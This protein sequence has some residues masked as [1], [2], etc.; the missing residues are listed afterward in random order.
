MV[1]AGYGGTILV[2]KALATVVI[3][4]LQRNTVAGRLGLFS[5]FD[6]GCKHRLL[7]IVTGRLNLFI[8]RLGAP[9]Y[10]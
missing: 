7:P 5:I 8:R 3:F 6:H 2:L 9:R 10:Q 1:I 4:F